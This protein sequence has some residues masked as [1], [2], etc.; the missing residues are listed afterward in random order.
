MNRRIKKRRKCGSHVGHWAL[1]YCQNMR[2]RLRPQQRPLS[3]ND[4]LAK[5]MRRVLDS[6]VA[7]PDAF[8]TACENVLAAKQQAIQ[9]IDILHRATENFIHRMDDMR[10]TLQW[11]KEPQSDDSPNPFQTA[12]GLC[13]ISPDR[14]RQAMYDK[15]RKQ[16]LDEVLRRPGYVWSVCGHLHT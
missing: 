13:E 8:K 16:S 7:A 1:T 6:A 4:A 5:L 3:R 12:V 14:F 10:H 2:R 9:A 11:L 15:L